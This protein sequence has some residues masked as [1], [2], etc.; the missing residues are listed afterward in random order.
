[1]PQLKATAAMAPTAI[2]LAPEACTAMRSVVR[3][4]STEPS[5][6]VRRTCGTRALSRA[7]VAGAGWPYGFPAPAETTATDG[8]TASR[9]A[10]VDEVRLP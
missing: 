7:I 6:S 3:S 4:T 9:K 1:M 2:R 10:G 8:A 5:V